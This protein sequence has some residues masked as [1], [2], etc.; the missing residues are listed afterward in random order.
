MTIGFGQ[1]ETLNNSL[2]AKYLYDS[3]ESLRFF[4]KV[5]EAVLRDYLKIKNRNNQK[6]K[7]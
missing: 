1:V 6:K 3:P 4:H 7:R 2:S 5:K